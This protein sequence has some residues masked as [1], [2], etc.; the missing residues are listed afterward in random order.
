MISKF[1]ALGLRRP[2]L[3]PTL[4]G[5]AWAFRARGWYR[6][7]PFLPLP[8][9]S[10]LRWRLDTAYGDPEANPPTDEVVRYLR[11]ARDLRKRM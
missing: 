1:A 7:A 8:P 5:T 10:Y 6:R 9:E 11:W 3:I 4:L 2:W